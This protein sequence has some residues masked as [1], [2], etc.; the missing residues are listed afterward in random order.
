MHWL[1]G[2]DVQVKCNTHTSPF[3]YDK[4]PI[5]IN[6]QDVDMEYFLDCCFEVRIKPTKADVILEEVTKNMD[7]SAAEVVKEAMQL[8]ETFKGLCDE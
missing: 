2:G 1:N 8:S 6:K 5:G 4:D 7:E 3:W